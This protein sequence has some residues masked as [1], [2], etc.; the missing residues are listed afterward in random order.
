MY[1]INIAKCRGCIYD[2]GLEGVLAPVS[3]S[4]IAPAHQAPF[5]VRI[6]RVLPDVD[7]F[8]ILA[9]FSFFAG[10]MIFKCLI[11]LEE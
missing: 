2:F 4:L 7:F 11:Q 6:K 3:A 10:T 9:H 1:S 5:Q 8:F